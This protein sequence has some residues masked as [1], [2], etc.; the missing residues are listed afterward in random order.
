[1]TFHRLLEEQIRQFLPEGPGEGPLNALL[2][3]ISETYRMLEYEKDRYAY[4]L[5]EQKQ[6]QETLRLSEKKYRNMIEQSTDIIYKIDHEGYFTHVNPVAERITGFSKEELLHTHYSLLVREDHRAGV[7]TFYRRQ[8]EDKKSTTYLEFPIITGEG[9]ERWIGQSVQYDLPSGELTALAMDITERKRQERKI[10]Q[11][12]EKYRNII[13][14]MNIGLVEVDTHQ[15]IQHC[16]QRFCDLSGYSHHELI[17]RDI[18]E[19]Q[20][21]GP[22]KYPVRDEQGKGT[23]IYEIPVRNKQGEERWW[24]V[25]EAPNYDDAG[26]QTGSVSIHMDVT[27]RKQLEYELKISK[28]KAEASSKAKETFLANMSHEIRTPLNAIIGMVRELSYE[29][30]SEQQMNYVK[31]ASSASQHLLSVLNNILDISKIEAGEF[32]IGSEPFNMEH[33]I[34]SVATIMRTTAIRKQLFLNVSVSPE[35]R[36]SLIGDPT[37]LGQVLLN[38]LGNALKFTEKGGVSIGC[39]LGAETQDAQ[40]LIITITDTGIG[41]DEAYISQIFTKF[42]QEDLSTSRHY[43]GTGLGMAI[44]HEL[45][46]LMSGSIQIDSRKNQGT[47]VVIRITLPVGDAAKPGEAATLEQL[48]HQRAIRVL[49]VEDNEFNRLIATKTLERNHCLVSAAVNGAEAVS[50]LRTTSFDMILMDLHMPVMDGIT[51]TRMIREELRLSTP[52]IALSA[53]AFKTE[54]DRCLAAGMNDYITKP[55]EESTLMNCILKHLDT[56]VYAASTPVTAPPPQKKLYSISGISAL[57]GGDQEY[58]KTLIEVF[59]RQAR[60]ALEQI[61]EALS[62]RDMKTLAGIAHQLKSGIDTF[63]IVSLQAGIREIEQEAREGRY[64][65]RL[66]DLA[67]YNGQVMTQV[68]DRLQAELEELQGRA[69][70]EYQP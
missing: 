13:A 54:S 66:E 30:L 47:S 17:G 16:N 20:S 64:S 50:K 8:L 29:P 4:F 19:F 40:D 46:Q 35:I 14:N 32:R 26:K 24:M 21:D 43:G 68:I 25:S 2:L 37:R 56:G 62:S 70:Y 41:M 18:K 55:F 51:A 27:E 44:S 6:M 10:S 61:R 53:N 36:S 28:H 38:L 3:R 31:Q 58:L 52:I 39:E 11:Q 63:R 22:E 1:M 49:L 45:I 34:N 48:T 57:S 12:E 67:Q 23:G 69:L 5:S 9:K 60:Q 42:S 59:I 33:L 7:T 65:T 15:I